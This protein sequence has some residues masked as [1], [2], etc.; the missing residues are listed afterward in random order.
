[1]KK[2][3]MKATRFFHAD[4]EGNLS[5]L[6]NLRTAMSYPKGDNFKFNRDIREVN[7]INELDFENNYCFIMNAS[8]KTIEVDSI[9]E[10]KSL[11]RNI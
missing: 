1:M 6:V 11:F 4:V 7:S 8:G 3:R 2:P 9:E 5:R 10:A